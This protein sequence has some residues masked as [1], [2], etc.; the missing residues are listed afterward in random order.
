MQ[1]TEEKFIEELQEKAKQQA[2]MNEGSPLP[3][4]AK[5]FASVIGLHYW[6]FLLIVSLVIAI[7]VSIWFFPTIYELAHL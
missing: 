1:I 4:W 7:P 5:P 6:Q 3:D 2:G